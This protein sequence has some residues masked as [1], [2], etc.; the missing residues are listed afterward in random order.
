MKIFFT[1]VAILLLINLN[2]YS[3]NYLNQLK[4]KQEFEKLSGAPLANKYGNVKAV[5]IVFDL[6]TEKIYY[7]NANIY[8]NHYHFCKKELQY[9]DGCGNFLKRNYENGNQRKYLL[10][11]LNFFQSTN[12]YFLEISPTDLM[13]KEQIIRIYNLVKQSSY[14]DKQ[15]SFITN[16]PRLQTITENLNEKIST[17][18]PRDIYG[19]LNYQAISKYKNVGVLKYVDDINVK[20][21]QFNSNNI[22]VLKSSPNYL[23]SVAGLI[24]TEFQTPLSHI[25]ILGLNR[26]IPICT[27]TKIFEDKN[28]R[29][30][31][32]QQVCLSVK[33]DTFKI[34]LDSSK[35]LKK[36]TQNIELEL[37]IDVDSLVNIEDLNAKSSSYVGSKASNFSELYHLSKNANF[38]TPECAFAIPFYFYIQHIK[39]A[40]VENLIDKLIHENIN[41]HEVI[42]KYLCQIRE[43]IKNTKINESLLNKVKNKIASHKKYTNFRFRSS[44]NAED[45]EGF[46]GAGLYASKTGKLGS[47]KKS[48]E[49]AIKT[50]WASIWSA[51]AYNEREYYNIDQKNV[52]MGILVHRSFP[53]EKVNGVAITKNIYRKNSNGFLVN[54]QLGNENVVKPSSGVICDQFLCFPEKSN[55]IHKNKTIIDVITYS[56]LNGNKLVMSES[57]IQNLAN[58]LDLI[59]KHY[60][61]KIDNWTY[62]RLAYDIEF[63]INGEN[64][65]LYIKQ[66]RPYN[67]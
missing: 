17:I 50:V 6:K 62:T 25:S 32:G 65:Q 53:N 29:K 60:A 63:K 31:D 51:K 13:S 11:N 8:K 44:T 42:N 36:H 46:S 27:Y 21:L 1:T 15:F 37:N 12:K 41:N 2:T 54:A 10:A 38:K 24:I 58:Q 39:K 28:I 30:L 22:L 40:K 64:R 34:I 49:K 57:E 5:K 61:G 19:N 26:K 56:N 16:S 3:H 48:I 55:N 14:L 47:Q 4:S 52:A 33:A 9:I 45:I 67:D 43:K 7:L 59:K 20:E 23:P 18:T 35:L 66:V